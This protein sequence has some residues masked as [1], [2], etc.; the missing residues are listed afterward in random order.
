[1]A[2]ETVK[3]LREENEALKVEIAGLR[4]LLISVNAEMEREVAQ[5]YV[6]GFMEGIEEGVEDTQAAYQAQT[7]IDRLLKREPVI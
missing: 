3:E 6:D 4:Q 7:F 2:R 5:K 1:M